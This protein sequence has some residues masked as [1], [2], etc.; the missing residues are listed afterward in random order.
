MFQKSVDLERVIQNTT[1]FSTKDLS[2]VFSGVHAAQAKERIQQLIDKVS[3]GTE[4]FNDHADEIWIV[5][6]SQ[7]ET[8][9]DIKLTPLDDF[10]I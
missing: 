1:Y 8:I 5:N 10:T 2:N 9:E 7:T 3:D 6:N 4:K